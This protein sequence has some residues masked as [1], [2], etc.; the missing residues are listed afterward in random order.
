MTVLASGIAPRVLAGPEA[1][2]SRALAALE[3]FQALGADHDV[4]GHAAVG[5]GAGGAW[6]AG[7]LLH[8]RAARGGRGVPPAVRWTALGAAR[9]NVA[10]V[11]AQRRDEG[12]KATVTLRVARFG[13]GPRKWRCGCARSR[14]RARR[15][16]RSSAERVRLPAE[17]AATVRLTFEN[18][19]DVEVTLPEDAL[20]EDGQRAAAALS[21]APGARWGWRRGWTPAARQALERFL[22]VAPEVETGPRRGSAAHRARGGRTRG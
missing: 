18:A 1:E 17:G 14:A 7:A 5:A 6:A 4:D 10:L 2:P 11:S 20:P 19:G 21:G 16:A 3:S 8:G 15:R 9:D 22:A 12:A 13:A